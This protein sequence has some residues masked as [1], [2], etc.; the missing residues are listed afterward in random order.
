MEIKETTFAPKTYLVWRKGI[1][2]KNIK[3]RNLKETLT[4]EESL[5]PAW[6]NPIQRIGKRTFIISMSRGR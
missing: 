4:I 5:L 3:E 6:I 1:D 2:I